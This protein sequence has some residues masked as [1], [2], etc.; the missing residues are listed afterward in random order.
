MHHT[1]AQCSESVF[2]FS[3]TEPRK[4]Q[5]P[6]YARDDSF[7]FGATVV[8][9]HAEKELTGMGS[10]FRGSFRALCLVSAKKD[11]GLG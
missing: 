10:A 6:R 11:G 1:D 4:Q 2:S 3:T 7:S 8:R 5:V 9:R